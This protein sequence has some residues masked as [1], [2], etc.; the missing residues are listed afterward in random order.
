MLQRPGVCALG[1]RGQLAGYGVGAE[2]RIVWG[3]AAGT[4]CAWPGVPAAEQLVAGAH[5]LAA[6]T[7]AGPPSV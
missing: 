4:S 5:E 3:A 6:C 7:V 1:E 2:T